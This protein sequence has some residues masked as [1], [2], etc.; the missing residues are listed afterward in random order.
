MR[1][2]ALVFLSCILIAPVVFES[3]ACR[4]TPRRADAETGE[5]GNGLASMVYAADPRAS[6]QLVR[7]F[8][9]VE[10]NAWRWTAGSFAV[11][12]R[13]PAGASEKGGTL[14]F[15]FVI[16]EPE[17]DKLKSLTLSAVVGGVKLDPETYNSAGDQTYTR[18]VP[19][20]AFKNDAVTAEFTLDKVMPPAGRDAR[21]LGVIMN[22]IGFEAKP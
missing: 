18:D 19:P 22:A 9:G 14:I 16:P 1:R 7:G 4:R 5:A 15:K 6:A 21:E 20:A 17:I 11:T 3:A 8:Y 10:Q 2:L 12:L 13:P